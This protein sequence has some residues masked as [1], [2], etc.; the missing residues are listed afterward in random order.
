[1]ALFDPSDAFNSPLID[2]IR[3]NY[4]KASI[5]RQGCVVL[6]MSVQ[7]KDGMTRDAMVWYNKSGEVEQLNWEDDEDAD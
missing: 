5:L 7:Y 4:K 3:I 2:S 1:M 6:Y